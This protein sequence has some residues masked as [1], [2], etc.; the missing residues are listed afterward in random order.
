MM[1]I[2]IGNLVFWPIYIFVGMLPYRA[3]QSAINGS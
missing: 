1:D 2:V 3:M